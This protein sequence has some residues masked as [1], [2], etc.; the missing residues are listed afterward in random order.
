MGNEGE[1]RRLLLASYARADGPSV[2]SPEELCAY[3]S[4]TVEDGHSRM[5]QYYSVRKQANT[6]ETLLGN[7]RPH[8]RRD[9]IGR[10]IVEDGLA[11]MEPRYN[12][13]PEV[14]LKI[15]GQDGSLL[16][17][18][19]KQ[20]IALKKLMEAYCLRQGLETDRTCFF[21]AGNRL[22]D[23]QTPAELNMEDDDMIYVQ[24]NTGETLLGNVSPHYR[25][26]VI[27]RVIIE[28]GLAR[29][30]PRYLSLKVKGQDGSLVHFM[31]KQTTALKK[32]MEAYCFR[33]G[34]EMDRTCFFFAGNRLRESQTPA[35]LNMEDDD[36][37]YRGA[38]KRKDKDVESDQGCGGAQKKAC[39]IRAP[40]KSTTLSQK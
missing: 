33:Q 37:I 5:Q 16:H 9:V 7:V 19:M 29:M 15:K 23:T 11:R 4:E 17:F 21:F 38:I 22:R 25:R 12:P 20:T 1:A 18:K 30:E 8:Y 10:E 13:K 3:L 26:D 24:V 39:I 31:I 14:F 27:G 6:G 40:V 36:M 35:E 2:V 28:D 34:L 32:L